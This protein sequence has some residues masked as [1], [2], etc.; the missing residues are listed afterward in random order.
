MNKSAAVQLAA[1][2]FPSWRAQAEDV[3]RLDMW[4]RGLHDERPEMPQKASREYK[5]IA[6][7]ARTPWL[8]LVVSSMAQLMYVD[9]FRPSAA[10]ADS[11]VVP[12]VWMGWQANQF[13]ARQSAV[14]RAMLAHGVAFVSVLPGEPWPV[15]RGHSARRMYAEFARHDDEWP[16]QALQ[17]EPTA[18]NARRVVCRLWTEEQVFT[19]E[20]NADGS[21]MLYVDDQVHGLG[22]VPIVAYPNVPDLDGRVESDI[23]K[24]LPLGRRLEQTTFDRLVIQRF[25]AWK[26]RTIAGMTEPETDAE[27]R[28]AQIR[29]TQ[30]DLLV[31]ESPDTRFGTL[32]ETPLDGFLAAHRA[33]VEALSATSQTS[34][35][36]FGVSQLVNISAEGLAAL[37]LQAQRKAAERR[38]WAGEWHEQ[39]LRLVGLAMGD[40]VAA[41]DV[42]AEVVWR[43]VES[44]SLAAAADALGKLATQLGI[45][46][47]ALWEKIPGWTQQ[48]VEHARQMARE[49]DQVASMLAEFVAQGR[50]I[51]DGV[52]G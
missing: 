21:D 6:E 52:D 41:A 24:F 44:K 29:L 47:E 39:T 16:M 23:R 49:G 43:D 33:D 2:M 31:S 28:A 7:L 48:D 12:A 17:V 36:A 37:E 1:A 13:D 34:P 10:A 5:A 50:S 20:A 35:T 26:V 32:D 38:S 30:T 45:P 15:M 3:D 8:G 46:A 18:R 22:V 14:H 51:S 9:A 42:A 11:G 19:L 4:A 40:E 27:K 25:S